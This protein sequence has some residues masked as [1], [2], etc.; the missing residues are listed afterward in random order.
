MPIR[1]RQNFSRRDHRPGQT[2]HP[3]SWGQFRAFGEQYPA[4]HTEASDALI[5]T[6]RYHRRL[7]GSDNQQ[8]LDASYSLARPPEF[9]AATSFTRR[10]QGECGTS[11]RT[12][13]T[14]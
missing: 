6:L 11:S 14:C 4:A 8:D 9:W 2:T 10:I 12:A 5:A 3:R 13:S 7:R 1:T